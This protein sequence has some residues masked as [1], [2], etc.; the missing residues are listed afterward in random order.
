MSG[1][2]RAGE[3]KLTL[4]AGAELAVAQHLEDLL[5][6]EHGAALLDELDGP[7]DEESYLVAVRELAAWLAE[8]LIHGVDVDVDWQ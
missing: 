6:S 1:R 4:P 8:G 3:G 7:H 5:I 2:K